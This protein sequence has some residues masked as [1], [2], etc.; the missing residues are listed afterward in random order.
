M[1]KLY[2]YAL[3][4]L[5]SEI[6]V[7]SL[8][9]Q[10]DHPNRRQTN[11]ESMYAERSDP[12]KDWNFYFLLTIPHFS[13]LFPCLPFFLIVFPCFPLFLI[14]FVCF[15]FVSH[16]FRVSC[17]QKKARGLGHSSMHCSPFNMESS[18]CQA[19]QVSYLSMAAASPHQGLH[20]SSRCP[21]PLFCSF[22]CVGQV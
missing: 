22:Y 17:A 1:S 5:S 10:S 21:L 19:L 13:S 18:A 15:P 4:M 9:L 6:G 2:V 11:V 16:R 20:W 7:I 8:E 3:Y 12:Q 14:V